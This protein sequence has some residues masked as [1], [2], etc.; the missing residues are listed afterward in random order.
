MQG[1]TLVVAVLF[2]AL[3]IV[4]P[5]AYALAA[6]IGA[7]LAYPYYLAVSIGT[8]ELLV[9]RMVVSALLMRCLLDDDIRSKFVWCRL[10]TW[11]TLSIAV[12]V[13]MALMTYQLPFGQRLENR[14]GFVMDTWFAY[15]AARL[16]LTNRTRLT[17]VIKCVGVLL[18]PLAMLGV[19]ESVTGWQPF[20]PLWHL[21][22]WY[23]QVSAIEPRWG[24]TRAVGPFGVSILFGINFGLF[25]PLIYWLRYEKNWHLRAYILSAIALVGGLSSM[26]SGPWVMIMVVGACL[27]ME[28]NKRWIKTLLVLFLLLC[29]LTQIASNRPFYHVVVSY[30]NPLGGAGWPR[31]KLI[32]VAIEYFH[33]WWLKGYGDQDPGWGH[34][35][36]MPRT[37]VTNEFILMG[38]RY[39]IWGIISLVAVLVVAFRCIAATYRKL[40][41]QRLKSLCW[42]CGTILVAV[43]ITWMSVSFFGQLSN[44]FYC[45][46]GLIGAMSHSQF[47]WQIP[48]RTLGGLGVASNAA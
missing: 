28:R 35:F 44:L 7:L 17:T 13:G 33:E 2:A 9:G 48:N 30:A 41:Y 26:S 22:P 8:V 20:Y 39:G 6:Y 18:V 45:V 1:V 46:L 27:V 34:Y 10:D 29:V 36:G 43:I 11:V 15:L 25:L 32:D 47:D 42:A 24:F 3:T 21:S 37:D 38:V 16:I 40:P 14:A 19:V 23:R 31:A 12:A 4:L 5:P